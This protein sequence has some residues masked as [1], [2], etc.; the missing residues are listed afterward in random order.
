[1]VSRGHVTVMFFTTEGMESIN[2]DLA[3]TAKFTAMLEHLLNPWDSGYQDVHAEILVGDTAF[4]AVG[5]PPGPCILTYKIG[6]RLKSQPFVR[7]VDVPVTDLGKARCFLEQAAETKATY[8]IPVAQ[9]LAPDLFLHCARDDLDP[10]HPA[11]WHHL[12]CSQFVILFLRYCHREGILPIQQ[13]RLEI[14]WS[15][16]SVK[17]TPA[18]L[19]R[20]LDEILA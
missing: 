10:I 7:L 11:T 12:F 19:R 5:R 13:K 3:L 8:D 14:L 15:E 9:M 18:H 17:W 1:M 2:R 20:K 6:N 4:S 16:D